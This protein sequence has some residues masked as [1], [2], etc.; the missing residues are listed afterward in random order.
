MDYFAL[1]RGTL[2]VG[3]VFL[4]AFVMGVIGYFVL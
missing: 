2:M 1:L 4:I 3:V